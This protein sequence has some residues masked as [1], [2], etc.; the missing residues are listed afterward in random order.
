[1]DKRNCWKMV[2]MP[3]QFRV[4]NTP[5]KVGSQPPR[6]ILDGHDF[7]SMLSSADKA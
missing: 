3:E 4:M 1:L 2:D 5:D 6:K 7:C